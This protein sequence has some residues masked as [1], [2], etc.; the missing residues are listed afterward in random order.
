MVLRDSLFNV[1]VNALFAIIFV[2][3][4]V[5]ALVEGHPF[6]W[7]FWVFVLIA[8]FFAYRAWRA[9]RLRIVLRAD[10]LTYRG[11]WGSED[12]A[13]DAAMR[14]RAHRFR[15]RI[16]FFSWRFVR[17]CLS[18][19]DGRPRRIALNW[20]KAE[21]IVQHVEQFQLV[22]V[23]PDM[24]ARFNGG[25]ELDF[26]AVRCRNDAMVLQGR[27]FALGGNYYWQFVG[28][29]FG[30]WPLKENG[31][32]ARKALAKVKC[33]EMD[34]LRM[35]CLLHNW[36]DINLAETAREEWSVPFL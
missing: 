33:R 20:R 36:G 16:G 11:A 10:G 35:F 21:R 13:F 4:P 17:I 6:W 31:R 12:Y 2:F 9:L 15:V 19:D 26:G 8:G 23:L 25:A 28:G 32:P 18:F 27:A 24:V 5:V 22:Q 29:R 30:V 1:L 34:N 7:G 3:P 14:L